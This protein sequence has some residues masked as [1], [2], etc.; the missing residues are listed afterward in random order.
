MMN[1]LANGKIVVPQ[2]PREVEQLKRG[3][4]RKVRK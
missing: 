1:K 3:N 4:R 2:T